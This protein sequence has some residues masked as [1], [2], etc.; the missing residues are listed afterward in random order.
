MELLHRVRDVATQRLRGGEPRAEQCVD[1]DGLSA[2]E[3]RAHVADGGNPSAD[4]DV[5]LG[6]RVGGPGFDAF[7]D[8]HVHAGGMERVR[9]HPPVAA[10]VS[11][12]GSDDDAA[13]APARCISARE[14]IPPEIAEESQAVAP[15]ESVTAIGGREG[16]ACENCHSL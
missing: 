16:I 3:Q 1:H 6:F 8:T 11:R 4:R 12:P 15:R 14:G 10:V 7:D 13:A 5:A 9:D 2:G